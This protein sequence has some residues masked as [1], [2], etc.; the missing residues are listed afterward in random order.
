[1]SA[2]VP[3]HRRARYAC[4]D[5]STLKTNI[6]ARFSASCHSCGA[7]YI[8]IFQGQYV[9]VPRFLPPRKDEVFF[10]FV[11]CRPSSISRFAKIYVKQWETA[12]RNA[13]CA[14]EAGKLLVTA[15]A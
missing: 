10:L 12:D 2:V 4:S 14:R 15:D 5:G 9:T 13:R 8:Y 3:K 11:F 7:Q 1:M 6:V